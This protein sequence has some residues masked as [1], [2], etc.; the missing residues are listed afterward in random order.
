MAEPPVFALPPQAVIGAYMEEFHRSK[1]D[2]VRF[3][4]IA[5]LALLRLDDLTTADFK[6]LCTASFQPNILAEL[7]HFLFEEDTFQQK[8][9]P[10]LQQHYGDD[11]IQGLPCIVVKVYL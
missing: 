9:V 5:Y 6:A 11:Y 4:M 1:S 3:R 10:P 2:E 8:C 7:L